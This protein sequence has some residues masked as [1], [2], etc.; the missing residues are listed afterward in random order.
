MATSFPKLPGYVPTHDCTKTEWKRVS[1][2]KLAEL[3]NPKNT[4]VPLY[5]L[6]RK[7]EPELPPPKDPKSMSLSQTQFQNPYGTDIREKFEPTFVKLDK[8]VLRFYGYFKE[9]VSESA[10][11][12]Y[13]IRRVVFSYYLEDSTLSVSEP[14]L[15][16]SGI[17]QGIFLKRQM[18]L[19]SDGS[20]TKIA[21]TDFLYL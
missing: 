11:E 5:A 1:H 14:R 10:M 21:L 20:G 6:P 19:R 12:T 8:Q 2:D 13:R 9:S 15:Q 18:I 4:P 3:Q 7:P 16:N 17:P